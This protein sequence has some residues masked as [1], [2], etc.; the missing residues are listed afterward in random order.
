MYKPIVPLYGSVIEKIEGMEAGSTE[1]VFHLAD[2][3]TAEFWHEQ[4]CCEHVEVN[5]VEGDPQD[6][7]GLPVLTAETVTSDAKDDVSECGT[8]TF[9]R[10]ATAKGWVVVRWLGESNGYYSEDVDFRI[11]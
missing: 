2:G 1:M 3:R 5:D 8:W 11:V 4:D 9:Y 10:F 7:I 6:L